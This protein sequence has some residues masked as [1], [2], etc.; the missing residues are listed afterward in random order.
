MYFRLEKLPFAPSR[1]VHGSS[2]V[3]GTL[4]A[5]VSLS[6]VLAG[7]GSSASTAAASKTTTSASVNYA[8]AQVAHYEGPTVSFSPP[9][10]PLTGASALRGKTVFY[11]PISLSIPEYHAIGAAFQYAMSLVG[12]HVQFCSGEA[13][14]SATTA[15][16]NEAVGEGAA[17]V[18]TDAVPYQFDAAAFQSLAS[19]H[20]P[21]MLASEEPPAGQGIGSDS[22]SYQPSATLFYQLSAYWIVADSNGHANILVDEQADSSSQAAYMQLALDVFRRYCPAC[23][24]YMINTPTAE[25]SHAT[26]DVSAAL[27]SH[28]GINYVFTQYDDLLQYALPAIQSAGYASKVKVASTTAILSGLQLLASKSYVYADAGDSFEYTG[29]AYADQM[30]RMM[31]GKPLVNNYPIPNRIFTRGNAGGLQLTTAAE[32]NGSWYGSLSFVGMFK[33]LWGVG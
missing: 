11:I 5:V 30:L 13:N 1:R 4:A 20:I 14:P 8:K 22:V 29:F 21:L 16:V 18:V 32:S 24:W 9:G 15:C 25:L 26:S 3:P 6:V 23:K 27:L 10:P 2:L 28:P 17:G 33:K 7:C 31:L 12:V 19:H